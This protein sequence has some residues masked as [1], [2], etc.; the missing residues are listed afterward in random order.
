[1]NKNNKDIE[2]DDKIAKK[3]KSDIEE[4]K[5]KD[6]VNVD[7]SKGLSYFKT[8]MISTLKALV[9]AYALGILI[10]LNLVFTNFL[11]GLVYKLFEMK[12]MAANLVNW[13]NIVRSPVIS[14]LSIVPIIISSI[15]ITALVIYVLSKMKYV[16]YEGE[17][18]KTKEYLS[19]FALVSL[20]SSVLL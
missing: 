14:F 6:V 17:P 18:K 8:S 16:F 13:A 19:I 4:N 10:E 20:L 7:E 5:S 2:E 12:Y 1:M 15:A 11:Y 3:D 9:G